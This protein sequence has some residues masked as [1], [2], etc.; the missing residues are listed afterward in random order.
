[1]DDFVKLSIND[2][3]GCI[4]NNFKVVYPPHNN[5]KDEFD[6]FINKEI[7]S[8]RK[9]SS[10]SNLRNF[11]NFIKRIL[12]NKVTEQIKGNVNLLDIAVG[13]GGDIFKWNESRIKNV[14]GFDKSKDSIESINPF[15]QGA[16]E[17]Y[18][19]S[20]DL[21]VNIE[22]AVGDAIQPTMELINN[23]TAFMKK[24][25]INGFEIMS[26][27]FAMHYFFQSEIA[28]RN[29]FKAFSPLLKK[30]GYFIGTTVDGK[31]ISNL[32]KSNNSFDS[33]LLSITKKYRAVTPRI[34]FGNKYTFKLNDTVDQGNYFNTMGESTEYLVSLPELKRI[35]SE[36]GLIPVYL[37]FFEPISKNTYTT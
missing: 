31:N 13:R 28:L 3:V 17:R 34:P 33:T 6:K 8:R 19:N 23:I 20:K 16:Q 37:N 14:F 24:N 4:N 5:V 22:F 36:Y 32:L 2:I 26:C 21:N 9:N 12:I 15:D 18:R 35:A 11:H 30:G 29:V 7:N 27:Q 1:M 25:N 10:I